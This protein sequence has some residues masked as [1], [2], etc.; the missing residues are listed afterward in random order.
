M[1]SQLLKRKQ[2]LL[3]ARFRSYQEN[4][5]NVVRWYLFLC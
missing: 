5:R 3:P 1:A 2:H 4:R